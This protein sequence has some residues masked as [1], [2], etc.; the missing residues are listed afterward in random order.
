MTYNG[1]HYKRSPDLGEIEQK[2]FGSKHFPRDVCIAVHEKGERGITIRQAVCANE[3]HLVFHNGCGPG[4]GNM[5]ATMS[6]D[7]AIE[8]GVALIQEAKKNKWQ[9]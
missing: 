5:R 1:L 3:L 9:K 8:L 4:G 7:E 2:T 6:Y